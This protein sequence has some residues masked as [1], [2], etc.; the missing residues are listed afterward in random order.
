VY[1]GGILSNITN[2]LWNCSL[3]IG[4]SEDGTLLVMCSQTFLCLS[5]WDEIPV[6]DFILIEGISAEKE[7]NILLL[8]QPPGS[9]KCD[10]RLA[11]F[12]G[13][14]KTVFDI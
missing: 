9:G 1:S 11:S 3:L 10:L 8:T 12:P 2:F 6:Q 14:N 13:T 5:L 4:L 7:T